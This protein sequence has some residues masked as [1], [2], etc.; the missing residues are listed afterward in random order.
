VDAEPFEDALGLT[1]LFDIVLGSRFGTKPWDCTWTGD[2]ISVSLEEAGRISG[3]TG[4]SGMNRAHRLY[5]IAAVAEAASGGLS[6]R[7]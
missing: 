2:E 4:I 1:H 5:S 6:T 7:F 3:N